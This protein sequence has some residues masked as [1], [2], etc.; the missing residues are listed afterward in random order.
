MTNIHD[1]LLRF[2]L[3]AGFQVLASAEKEIITKKKEYAWQTI[4]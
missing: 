3:A 2:Q 1:G 4:L